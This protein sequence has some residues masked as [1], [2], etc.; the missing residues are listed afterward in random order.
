MDRRAP[1]LVIRAVAI[2][3]IVAF[4]VVVAGCGSRESSAL[5]GYATGTLAP[6]QGLNDIHLGDPIKS[7][8]DRFGSGKV[9]VTAGD[10]LLAADLHFPSQGLSFRFTADPGCQ[11]ALRAGGS[12]V[13]AMMGIRDAKRFLTDFPACASMSLHSIGVEDGGG[14]FGTAFTGHTAK[15]SKLRMTRAELFEHDGPGAADQSVSSV[16][17]SADE[18]QFEQFAFAGGLLAYVQK[19]GEGNQEPAAAHW[20]VVKMAVVSEIK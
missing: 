18:R 6:G 10:E 9:S 5:Q 15:G 20:K 1:C 13:Q 17:D 11:S 16:L 4:G 3:A 12:T 19:E 8:L 14:T 2:S 7:F